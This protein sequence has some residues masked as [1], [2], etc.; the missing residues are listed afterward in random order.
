ME[1][2][3]PMRFDGLD[4]FPSPCFSFTHQL[5]SQKMDELVGSYGAYYLD[6][7][8]VF[9]CNMSIKKDMISSN[10]NGVPISFSVK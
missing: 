5:R 1:L 4:K 10:V 3:L 6:L 9:Y 7:V 8:R 2:I